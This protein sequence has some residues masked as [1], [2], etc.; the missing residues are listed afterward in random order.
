MTIACSTL[1]T[2]L[3]R[4]GKHGLSNVAIRAKKYAYHFGKRVPAFWCFRLRGAIVLH[5]DAAS[6]SL[7]AIQQSGGSMLLDTSPKDVA[8]FSRVLYRAEA[9]ARAIEQ[10]TGDRTAAVAHPDLALLA[11]FA[12]VL[13][14]LNPAGY[15]EWE[16]IQ[17]ITTRRPQAQVIVLGLEESEDN[18][19]RM[20]EAG[21]SGYIPPSTSLEGLITVLRSV[22]NRE[23]ACP[24]DVTYVLYA[25]LARLAGALRAPRPSPILTTRERRVLDLLSQSMTNKEIATSLCISEYTA[26]NHVHRILKKLGWN[27]RNLARGA[28]FPRLPAGPAPGSGSARP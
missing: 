8:V 25:H 11:G 17:A 9:L 6:G 28:D 13:I 21:A 16:L 14:D 26:K 18:V 1:K 24:P 19:V 23:F 5:F 22:Q 4:S 27:S 15:A 10:Q 12:V 3:T 7:S 2:F 20:A